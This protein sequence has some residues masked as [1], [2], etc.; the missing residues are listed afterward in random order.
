MHASP[1][2]LSVIV[3]A[4]NEEENIARTIEAALAETADLSAEIIVADSA[5][6]DRT[7]EIAARYPVHVVTLA[8]PAQ[9]SCGLGA[10]LGYQAARGAYLYV[11]DGDMEMLPGFLGRALRRLEDDPGLAGVCGLIIEAHVPN[12][13]CARRDAA[14]RRAGP[15]TSAVPALFGGGVYRRAAIERVGYLTNPN[16]HSNEELEL[17]L[18]LHA[19]GWRLERLGVPSVRH[20][21]H[22][23]PDF[24]L[25]ALRWRTRYCWG[26]GELIRASAGK[27]WFREALLQRNAAIYL[28]MLG[29]WIVLAAGLALGLPGWVAALAPVGLV[30]LMGARKRN[31]A[32][33]LHAVL[34]W[35]LWAAGTLAGLVLPQADP[36]RP[37]AAREHRAIAPV[38]GSHSALQ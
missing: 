1:I 12:A 22:R 17:G 13:D 24:A 3:K 37:I 31:L 29:F 6:T 8:D 19:A 38:G 25:H 18:R 21:G 2:T 20:Y 26:L 15:G 7:A 36:R 14:V 16:L 30:L 33:G 4:L 9:R 11:V 35:N 32:H 5:S 23:L 27:P 34:N 28:A 10:Q